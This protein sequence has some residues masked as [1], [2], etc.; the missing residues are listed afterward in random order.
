M[1]TDLHQAHERLL[2]ALDD[3][4]ALTAVAQPDSA[5]IAAVR[6]KLS[7]ASGQRRRLVDE[8]SA[9]LIETATVGEAQAVRTLQQRI[10]ESQ[11]AS[12]R[13]VGAWSIRKVVEDWDGYRAASADM[14]AAMRERIAAE[15]RLLYP[16][17]QRHKLG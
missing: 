17:L 4:E 14:R 8:A 15:K 5:A 7:R 13:H 1:L 2:A 12:S 9:R 16:L 3:L 6:W 10:A 11:S